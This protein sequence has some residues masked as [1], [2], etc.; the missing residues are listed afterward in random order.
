MF[1]TSNNERRWCEF[2]L[3]SLA[4]SLDIIDQNLTLM[5]EMLLS[6]AY[7]LTV[8]EKRNILSIQQSILDNLEYVKADGTKKLVDEMNKGFDSEVLKRMDEHGGIDPED[9]PDANE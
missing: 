9:I 4:Y 6:A 5:G 7:D 8:S 2:T 3:R 1:K